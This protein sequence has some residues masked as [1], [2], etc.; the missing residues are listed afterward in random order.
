M[1]WSHCKAGPALEV[2]SAI[3]K[4]AESVQ[5]YLRTS[6]ADEAALHARA[7]GMAVVA[8]HAMKSMRDGEYVKVEMCGHFDGVGHNVNIN[9][10]HAMV[11]KQD[12]KPDP[13]PEAPGSSELNDAAEAIKSKTKPKTAPKPK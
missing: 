5:A 10:I 13:K 2:A 1:S 4:E 8:C 9:I 12:P 6:N 3:E 11:I 7:V